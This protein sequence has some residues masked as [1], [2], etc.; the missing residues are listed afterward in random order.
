[1]YDQGHVV[2]SPAQMQPRDLR[3]GVDSAY[4][5]FYSAKSIARRFPLTGKRSRA[6]WLVYNLF[7]RK[8]SAME[9]IED[10]APVT[11]EPECA[12]NPPILPLK[13]EWR[14]AVLEGLEPGALR[15]SAE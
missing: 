2:F 5:R 10:I 8:A 7:M 1:M 15:Q 4:K 11:P 12:P 13:R 6:Q 9:N 14:D 3:A